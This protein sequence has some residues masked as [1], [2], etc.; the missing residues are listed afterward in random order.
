MSNKRD[1]VFGV[2]G[3]I[4]PQAKEGEYSGLGEGAVFGRSSEGKVHIDKASMAGLEKIESEKSK[5]DADLSK[6][7]YGYNDASPER[8]ARIAARDARKQERYAEQKARTDARRERYV[9]KMV[10]KGRMDA[11]QAAE[12]FNNLRDITTKSR[13]D[14]DAILGPLTQDNQ[15]YDDGADAAIM[16]EATGKFFIN[17]DA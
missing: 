8:K 17:K 5:K 2:R 16:Q 6:K 7:Y 11:G 10:S 12:R 13:L 4:K 9:D 3:R 15:E 14:M 1:K